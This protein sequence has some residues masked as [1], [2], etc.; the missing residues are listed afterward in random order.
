[1]TGNGT[2]ACQVELKLMKLVST[3]K[4]LIEKREIQIANRVPKIVPAKERRL[5]S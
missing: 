1:M 3:L 2:K 4:G 5:E